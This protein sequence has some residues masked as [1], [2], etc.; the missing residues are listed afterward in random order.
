[1]CFLNNYWLSIGY[2]E[3]VTF[4][5]ACSHNDVSESILHPV[6]GT[7][8]SLR[9]GRPVQRLSDWRILDDESYTWRASSKS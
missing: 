8:L 1:M 3:Q 5:G 6:C 2:I 4:V 9:N 7:F